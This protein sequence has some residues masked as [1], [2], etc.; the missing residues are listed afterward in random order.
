[1]EMDVSFGDC[2]DI[3][4]TSVLLN[5]QFETKLFTW[6]LNNIQEHL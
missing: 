3:T 5:I 1:M 2:F 6:S 4:M